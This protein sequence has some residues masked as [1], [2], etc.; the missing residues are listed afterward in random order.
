[1]TAGELLRQAHLYEARRVSRLGLATIRLI[2]GAH[3]KVPRGGGGSGHGKLR[4]GAASGTNP[5]LDL[6][7]KWLPDASPPNF[8]RD[9]HRDDVKETP[10]YFVAVSSD[11]PDRLPSVPRDERRVLV[12]CCVLRR[13]I[14]PL[15]FRVCGLALVGGGERAWVNL[16]CPKAHVT[17]QWPVRRCN[18]GDDCPHR[19]RV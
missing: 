13:P 4:D 11:H 14:S 12:T 5:G 18:A 6:T 9:P 2:P 17:D 7:K 10:V 15:L 8:G 1:M 19:D 3:I 16:K